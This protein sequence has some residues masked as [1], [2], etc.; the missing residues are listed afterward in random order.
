MRR[1]LVCDRRWLGCNE[2]R[3]EGVGGVCDDEDGEDGDE[4][5]AGVPGEL[6]VGDMS[7][8]DTGDSGV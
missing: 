5:E 1:S 7:W 2:L 8:G 4:G 3:S 6:T